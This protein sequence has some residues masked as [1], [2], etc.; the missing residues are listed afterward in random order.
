MSNAGGNT[1]INVDP[2]HQVTLIGVNPA[3]LLAN[4][5]LFA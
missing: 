1:F 3:S 5:F 2:L 4:D